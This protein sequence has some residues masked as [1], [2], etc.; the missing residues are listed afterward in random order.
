MIAMLPSIIR[1][2]YFPAL[3]YFHAVVERLG[4]RDVVMD[5]NDESPNKA[6]ERT[7]GLRLRFDWFWFIHSFECLGIISFSLSL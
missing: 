7:A 5:F 1:A 6:L 2:G 4:W 3:S